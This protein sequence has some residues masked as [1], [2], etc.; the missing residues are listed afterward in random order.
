MQ[1]QNP[2]G[3]PVP[4]FAFKFDWWPN[5]PNLAQLHQISKFRNQIVFKNTDL[6]YY[7]T[8]FAPNARCF[9]ILRPMQAEATAC[10]LKAASKEED[11]PV[12]GQAS[13]SDQTN[14]QF[15]EV[16]SFVC[17]MSWW[18]CS[19]SICSIV[20]GQ[21]GVVTIIFVGLFIVDLLLT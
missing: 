2:R 1:S 14:R 4:L 7:V 15:Q 20:T 16:S 11:Q 9:G 12:Q 5:R 3:R 17:Q 19:R 8:S 21:C 10:K 6:Q 13:Q 18:F